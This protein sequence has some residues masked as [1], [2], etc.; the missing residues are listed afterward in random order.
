M[1]RLCPPRVAGRV[2]A[3]IYESEKRG[4]RRSLR[5]NEV[6]RRLACRNCSI[7]LIGLTR[8]YITLPAAGF[9]AGTAVVGVSGKLARQIEVVVDDIFKVNVRGACVSEEG[10]Q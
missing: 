6:C 7:G 3:Q 4:L 1:A 10:D 8:T 5:S 9:A 2:P